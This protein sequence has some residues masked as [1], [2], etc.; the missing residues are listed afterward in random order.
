MVGV[1]EFDAVSFDKMTPLLV[2]GAVP[3]ASEKWTDEWLLQCFGDDFG[4]VFDRG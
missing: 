4:R 3:R 2:K 1:H